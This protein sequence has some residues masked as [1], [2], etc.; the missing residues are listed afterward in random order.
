MEGLRQELNLAGRAAHQLR[1]HLSYRRLLC[2]PRTLC[3]LSP[4]W[5]K[6]PFFTP[7]DYADD[8]PPLNIPVGIFRAPPDRGSPNYAVSRYARS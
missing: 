8:F 3:R 4:L 6:L 1:N 7:H 5:V 2:L